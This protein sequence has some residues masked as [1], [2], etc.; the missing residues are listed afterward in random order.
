[1][2]E[3]ILVPLDGST[4]AERALQPAVE[5]AEKF[6]ARVTLLCAIGS[7]APVFASMGSELYPAPPPASERLDWVRSQAYLRNI[8]AAWPCKSVPTEIRVDVGGAPEVIVQTAEQIGADLIVMS[9][10]GR[11][12]LSRFLYGS[13]AEAVLRGTQRPLLLIPVK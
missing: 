8:E 9:T 2:I 1:M 4:L 10:H 5:L 7:E 13:V 3:R 12:R 6:G 11:S